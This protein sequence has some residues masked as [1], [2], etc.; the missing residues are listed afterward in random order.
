MDNETKVHLSPFE[1]ELMNNSEW[2][3]TKNGILRKVQLLLGDVQQNIAHFIQSRTK[4]FPKEVLAISPKISKGE[5]YHGLPWLM[6]DYPRYF[7]K[8]NT[9]AIRTMFWWGNFFSTTLHLS[10]KYKRE[11]MSA[12]I[13]SYQFFK[14]NGFYCCIND[15]PWQHHFEEANYIQV[16]KL[17]EEQFDGIILEKDFIKLSSKFSLA[18]WDQAIKMLSENFLSLANCIG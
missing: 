12:I 6:L 17:T 14:Q 3:L 5:N 9:F 8:E 13:H 7:D 18:E 10:G 1:M 11:Y 2:I 15:D 16:N 4:Q